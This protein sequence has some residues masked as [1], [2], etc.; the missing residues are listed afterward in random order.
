MFPELSWQDRKWRE[1]DE[2]YKAE[3]YSDA[4]IQQLREEA[5]DMYETDRARNLSEEIRTVSGV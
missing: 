3:G 5:R 2:R 1:I 4:E